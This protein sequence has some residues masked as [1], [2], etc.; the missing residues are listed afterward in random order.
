MVKRWPL[1]YA[2]TSC[3]YALA[4]VGLAA[5]QNAEGESAHWDS[6]DQCD[7]AD[8]SCAFNAL[9][10]RAK[11]VATA[12]DLRASTN[13]TGS[14]RQY[15][16]A[17]F[18]RKRPC[19]CNAACKDHG[20]C[21][22][23]YHDVC[24]HGGSSGHPS[25]K[26]C[27]HT[28]NVYSLDWE[29]SGKQFFD[30]FTFVTQDDV[31]GAHQFT[32]RHEAW[33]HRTATTEGGR[34][35][36]RFGGLRTPSYV[37]EAY[38]RYSLNIH[39]NKAWSPDPGFLAVLHYEKLP[40]GC[41][42]W[43]SF[44]AMNSDQVWPK[45]GELDILEYANDEK[46]KVT[47][48]IASKCSLDEGQAERCAPQGHTKLHAEACETSYFE[49]KLGCMPRQKQP[50]GTWLN[51]HPGVIVAEWADDHITIFH[52]PEDEIPSD[53]HNNKP[54]PA[55]WSKR[56]VVAYMPFEAGCASHIGPQELVLNMQLCGDWA[57]ATWDGGHCPYESG[58]WNGHGCESGL[59]SP[60]DCCTKF[61]TN[62]AREM[63]LKYKQY[64]D[65]KSL[66]VFTPQGATGKD[67]GT[68]I[69]GGKPLTE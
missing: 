51:S 39:T 64:M 24:H 65:I 49:G 1:I 31:H 3:L 5:T 4:S 46:N 20:N 29:A 28:S 57:G 35:Q 56:W 66:K 41:G 48:H 63:N 18:V 25:T 52:I 55:T 58:L 27:Y 9:Q 15:G 21:C 50:K 10:K 12:A 43:P 69:R 11:K 37:G 61:V 68:Y 6:D 8:D 36:I 45:G 2:S 67:S 22:G 59:S 7:A 40:H 32:D 44:W 38:K 60:T 42:I 14:C 53:L 16:C 19:Q 30:K 47:F 34:A 54:N 17:G 23:D 13:S 26:V 33:F 62:P